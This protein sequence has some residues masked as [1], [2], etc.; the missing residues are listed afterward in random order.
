M[1]TFQG[2][3]SVYFDV[4]DT[5]MEWTQC[6]KDDP[7][8]VEI[9]NNGFVFYKRPIQVHVDELRNQKMAGNTV[10]VWS[11]GGAK[12]AEAVLI[13]LNLQEYVDVVLTKPDF[14]YDDKEVNYWFPKKRYYF[15]EEK[16]SGGYDNGY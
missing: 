5:L 3:R 12:W 13:A 15:A 11:A 7:L 8:A 6:E 14:Y 1:I 4:D 9:K 2:N 10:V 16:T